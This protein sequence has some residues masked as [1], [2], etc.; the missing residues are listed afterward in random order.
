MRG[1]LF[2]AVLA[3]AGCATN[4]AQKPS[5]VV[6]R[7]VEVRDSARDSFVTYTAPAARQEFNDGVFASHAD[8]RLAA[9]KDRATGA[10]T[11]SLL[12]VVTYTGDW[13]QYDSVSL[14]SGRTLAARA[15][16]KRVDFCGVGCPVTE[17]V[18]VD[19]PPEE[20]AKWAGGGV[21]IRL[22]GL[23]GQYVS[24]DISRNYV[25]GFVK[26]AMA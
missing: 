22:N 9:R 13:R 6:A 15:S 4:Y 8:Y 16:S 18:Q 3:M 14:P 1:V 10:F 5:E 19:I 26:A 12:V 23:L 2:A 24:L 17:S 20:L 21:R 11:Y 25:V 7:K